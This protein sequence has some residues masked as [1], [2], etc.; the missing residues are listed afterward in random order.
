M[1][2]QEF[3]LSKIMN[4]FL[5]VTQYGFY[6][7]PSSCK[8]DTAAFEYLLKNPT[9]GQSINVQV[10]PGKNCLD[11]SLSKSANKIFL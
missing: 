7:I 8:Q 10:K 2:F 1:S 9:T 11:N 6:L 3:I 5:T 4:F